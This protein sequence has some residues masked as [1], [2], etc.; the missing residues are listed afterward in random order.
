MSAVISSTIATL[1]G[2]GMDFA[3]FPKKNRPPLRQ[4]WTSQDFSHLKPRGSDTV[5]PFI[6]PRL[7][8]RFGG[9]SPTNDPQSFEPPRPLLSPTGDTSCL[10]LQQQ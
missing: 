10:W 3:S 7:A 8:G 9:D 1:F 6:L 4:R 2:L 5:V